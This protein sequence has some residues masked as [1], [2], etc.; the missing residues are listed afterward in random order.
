MSYQTHPPAREAALRRTVLEVTKSAIL[1]NTLRHRYHAYLAV[2]DHPDNA[3]YQLLMNEHE[4]RGKFYGPSFFRGRTEDVFHLMRSAASTFGATGGSR[5]V[6][7][8]VAVHAWAAGGSPPKFGETA[9]KS[10]ARALH[11]L[12]RQ[13]VHA[14]LQLTCLYSDAE[15][16]ADFIRY[17]SGPS[18]RPSSTDRDR[19]RKANAYDVMVRDGFTCPVTGQAPS[20]GGGTPVPVYILKKLVTQSMDDPSNARCIDLLS[21]FCQCSDPTFNVISPRNTLLLESSLQYQFK[22]AGFIFVATEVPNRYK[23]VPTRSTEYFITMLKT[24]WNNQGYVTFTD[25]TCKP[26][27]STPLPSAELL[28]AHAM[29]TTVLR[30][31]VLLSEEDQDKFFG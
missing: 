9:R 12:A 5:Y 1:D 7:A 24:R 27:A 20:K 26:G 11:G 8:A 2:L 13:W 3:D 22:I 31:T 14:M 10:I 30:G 16:D 28:R 17:G 25:H 6:C 23:I 15:V 18:S 4:R 19:E 29:L 21:H